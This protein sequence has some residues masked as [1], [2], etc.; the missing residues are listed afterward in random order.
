VFGTVVEGMDVLNRIRERDP[1]TD[2]EPGDAIQT[3]VIEES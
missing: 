1:Q 2:R 3:I